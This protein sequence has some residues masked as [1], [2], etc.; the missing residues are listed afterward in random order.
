MVVGGR[1]GCLLFFLVEKRNIYPES[2]FLPLE[3][4]LVVPPKR[5]AAAIS[6]T[7]TTSIEKKMDK[8]FFIYC[9]MSEKKKRFKKKRYSDIS[10]FCNVATACCKFF[11]IIIE[12]FL[13]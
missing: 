13:Y 10:I 3:K 8:S 6:P 12:I 1:W 5:L 9:G 4:V 7:Y 2:L 11:F